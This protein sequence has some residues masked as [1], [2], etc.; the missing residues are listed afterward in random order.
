MLIQG[1]AAALSLPVHVI[2]EAVER[3]RQQIAAMQRHAAEQ[4]EA[5]WRAAFRPHAIIL[6]ERTVPSPMFVAAVI[7]V[8]RL[9]RVDFDTS[10]SPVLYVR[11]AL[12]GVKQKLAE[13]G[14]T[15]PGYGRATGIIVNFKPDFGVK[16][17]LGGEPRE[18]FDEAYCVGE[19][20]LLI[21]GRPVP[22]GNLPQVGLGG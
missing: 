16:F 19:V 15:L 1:L 9:L 18:I 20:D 3:T 22:S 13:W 4:A 8:E 10:A 14:G 17:D 7:G 12:R 2:S 6:T 11:L 5:E 21:K